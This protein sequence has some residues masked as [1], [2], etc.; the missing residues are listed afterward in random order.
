MN[1]S[2]NGRGENLG[3]FVAE[4]SVLRGVLLLV[5]M[6]ATA[7]AETA[8]DRQCIDAVQY[9]VAYDKAG[10]KQ[11]MDVN[12]HKLCDGTTD[13]SATIGCFQRQIAEH[14]NWSRAIDACKAGSATATGTA[15]EKTGY[16][17]KFGPG[18]KG[19]PTGSAEARAAASEEKTGYIN[20][21]GP[22]EK[23]IPT[24]SAEAQAPASEEKTGYINKFGPGEKG[25]PTGSAEAR[26]VAT[27]QTGGAGVGWADARA[28]DKGCR[29]PTQHVWHVRCEH[30]DGNW[31][32][33]CPDMEAGLFRGTPMFMAPKRLEDRAWTEVVAIDGSC[34]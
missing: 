17:N 10:S 9:K 25:I 24:G 6:S 2:A 8:L 29:G 34:H 19:I 23:G 30:P 20:K 14:D 7:A 32:H 1:E 21:F 18:E 26:A 27:P 31:S 13:P 5:L 11:W 12:L 22:G 16:V 28:H 15:E 33:D 4:I 3:C